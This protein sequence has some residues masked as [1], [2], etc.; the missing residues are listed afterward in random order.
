MLQPFPGLPVD[1]GPLVG[2]LLVVLAAL[3]GLS[4]LLRFHRSR[5]LR[6]A[7]FLVMIGSLVV[8]PVLTSLRLSSFFG[9]QTARAAAQEQQRQEAEQLRA[10]RS[11]DIGPAFDPHANPLVEQAEPAELATQFARFLPAPQIGVPAATVAQLPVSDDGT[12]TDHDGLTDY[13]EGRVGT[14]P[15]TPTPT[16][17]GCPTASKRAGSS[18]PPAAGRC[19]T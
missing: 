19:G 4:L 10:L 14:D 2:S 1:V 11:G 3:G 13:Q 5:P 7:I 9:P 15:N 12:D 6:N 16:T 18:T 8:D 17:T